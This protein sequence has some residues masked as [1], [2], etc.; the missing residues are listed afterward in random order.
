[1]HALQDGLTSAIYVLLPALAQS[2]GL[3]YAQVGFIR[4]VHSAAMAVMEI[5]SGLLSER[6]GERR[7]L[8]F[9]LAGGGLGYLSVSYA[10]GFRAVLLGLFVAGLGAAFQHALSSS[11]IGRTF[12]SDRRRVAFGV[13]NASGDA[14]KLV[15]T[16]TV[17]L[18]FGIGIGWQGVAGGFGMIAMVAAVVVFALLRRIDVGGPA[19][20]PGN[21]GSQTAVTT[22][23]EP[24]GFAALLAVVFVDTAIQDGFLV[25]VAFLMIEKQIPAGLGAFAI[26]LTLSGGVLG[27]FGCG[28]LAARLG[29][30]RALVLVEVLTALGIVAVILSPPLLAYC[31]LPLLGVVLQGSSTITYGTVGDLV[32]PD[33][34]ARAFALIYTAA[35]IASIGA[36]IS[37]GLIATHDGLTAAILSMA[38]VVLIPLPFCALLRPALARAKQVA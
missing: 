5:P 24:T 10:N 25:F 30:V 32:H 16:G 9:G 12:Q 31:L 1:M 23:R 29:V 17:S 14:G 3:N 37:F 21:H 28:H 13:Y 34:Q 35:A 15:A 8:A 4:A 20:Q 26:V 11:L 19:R 27:K 22:V 18:L 36:P 6:L 33:R 7:L 2:F 38:L